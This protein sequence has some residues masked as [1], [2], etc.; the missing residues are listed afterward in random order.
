M[1]LMILTRKL[2]Q[3]LKHILNYSRET[4]YQ[5]FVF[6]L[7]LVPNIYTHGHEKFYLFL[8]LPKM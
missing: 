1:L 7:S 8:K 5:K 3:Q 6:L 2:I 4:N